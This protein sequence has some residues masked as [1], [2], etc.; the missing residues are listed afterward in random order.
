MKWTEISRKVILYERCRAETWRD[1]LHWKRSALFHQKHASKSQSAETLL[2]RCDLRAVCSCCKIFSH[3][4]VHLYLF[5][6]CRLPQYLQMITEHYS[7]PSNRDS[8]AVH[9]AIVLTLLENGR[10]TLEQVWSISATLSLVLV[11]RQLLV[12]NAV[13]KLSLSSSGN[14]TRG[15]HFFEIKFRRIFSKSLPTGMIICIPWWNSSFLMNFEGLQVIS[16]VLDKKGLQQEAVKEI[17]EAFRTLVIERFVE[18][19]VPA[20]LPIPTAPI[21]AKLTVSSSL[22]GRETRKMRI[23]FLT[24]SLL[25]NF[26]KARTPWLYPFHILSACLSGLSLGELTGSSLCPA[27]AR[28]W[29]WRSDLYWLQCKAELDWPRYNM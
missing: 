4:D 21:F 11:G 12:N 15:T 22:Q 25:L 8:G 26:S 13:T 27:L 6:S 14:L 19:A 24:S 5:Q 29:I 1:L 9:E 3:C 7:T 10:L 2:C 16:A 23:L 18:Q 20:S 28:D 17:K